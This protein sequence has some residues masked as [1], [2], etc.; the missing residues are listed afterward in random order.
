MQRF[1]YFVTGMVA[2]LLSAI[3]LPAHAQTDNDAIMMNKQQWCTGVTY[4]HAQWNT[5]WEGTY[6]RT[7]AN[8][9]TLTTQSVMVMS[10][11]GI[12]DRL[13]VMV[14][15]PYISTNASSGTLHGMKGFQDLSLFV[16]WKPF[17][18]DWGRAGRL[19]LL[20]IVG[21]STPTNNYVIDFLPMSIGMGSTNIL[22]RAMA[23]YRIGSFFI[24]GSGT[25]I[26]RSNVSLDRTSYYTTQLY[27][28]NQV[29]M[30]D[31]LTWNGSIGIYKKYLVAEIMADNLTTLGGFDM[32]K[33]DMPFVSNRM[34]ATSVGAHIKYTFPFDTH[35]SVVGGSNYV[36]AGRNVGQALDFSIGGF[37]A[38]YLKR[39]ATAY[40]FPSN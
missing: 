10:N 19:S 22:W 2:L 34:N 1:R 9:G 23:Y 24:R 30:P 26:W 15:L 6:K 14:G 4:D 39:H 12:T 35:I 13:N 27:N 38:L 32:R 18:F 11:Y 16:K 28:T 21:F 37:Y 36:V 8:I 20:G 7:N 40:Q 17:S 33:N 5:Y 31:Q 3:L 25:Y 29:Q